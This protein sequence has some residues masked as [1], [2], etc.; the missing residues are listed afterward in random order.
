MVIAGMI[1][2]IGLAVTVASLAWLHARR[3]GLSWGRNP[4]SQY[5]ITP[6]RSGYR[7]ATIASV[8]PA[9]RSRSGLIVR[10]QGTDTRGGRVAGRVRRCARS[11]Q[12]VSDGRP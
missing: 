5:G 8:S 9:W 12:L 10:S 2:L 4:V 3:T 7:V 11:D 1:S 6:F